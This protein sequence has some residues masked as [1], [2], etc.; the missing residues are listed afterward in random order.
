[1]TNGNHLELVRKYFHYSGNKYIEKLEQFSEILTIT[2]ESINLISRKDIV[3]LEVNHILHSLAILK[4]VTFKKN[5]KVLDVGTGGGLPGLPLA[6][7][8]PNT[9]FML[10]DR[11]G[12][13][14]KA[15]ENIVKQLELKN[16][17]C[18]Q[19]QAVEV[20][21]KFDFIVSRAVTRLPEFVSWIENKIEKRSNHSLQNGV[22]YLKGGE[23]SE[24]L[25]EIKWDHRVFG[26][27]Q[28]FEESYFETKNIVHLFKQ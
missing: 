16:V 24:E 8:N 9:E 1:M 6:I 15:V 21:G 3:N 4:L 14:I 20:K 23:L 18:A 11:I 26:I 22:L 7:M 5:A 17:E 28:F 10:I 27:N 25:F 13:K 2:N 19:I 12:K